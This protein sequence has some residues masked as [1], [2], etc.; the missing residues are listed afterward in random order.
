M[1]EPQTLS[2]LFDRRVFVARRE[3]AVVGFLILSPVRL[4]NGW[5]FEQFVYRPGSPN[6]T[7]ELMVDTAMRSLAGGGYE[8]ATLGLAPLSS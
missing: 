3:E 1:V 6:G 5:L 8:Y 2:R 7:V 4:R